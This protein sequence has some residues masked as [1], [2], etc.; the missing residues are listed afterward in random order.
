MPQMI[1]SKKFI[2]TEKKPLEFFQREV[3]LA[4][5][6]ACENFGYSDPESMTQSN[7][8]ACLMF[9]SDTVIQKYCLK[10][11]VTDNVYS[12]SEYDIDILNGLLDI[13]ISLCYR[14]SKMISVYGYC[15]LCN[16]QPNLLYLW[17]N[18][19]VKETTSSYLQLVKR[20]QASAE[21][22]KRS[23][24]IEKGRNPVGVLALLNHDNGYNLPGV[25]KEA[26]APRLSA[27]EIREKMG[28]L[29]DKSGSDTDTP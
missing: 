2:A 6:T 16:I 26:V 3:P 25:S 13:Y 8:N 28:L 18:Q 24:L 22:S 19:I 15:L 5:R 20:L 7:F 9:I 4:F 21:E 14:Y 29:S 10:K 23:L 1:P 12:N 11:T 17:E 27:R